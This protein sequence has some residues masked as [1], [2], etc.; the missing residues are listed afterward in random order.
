MFFTNQFSRRRISLLLTT[1]AFGLTVASAAEALVITN[2]FHFLD[3]TG[4]NP[5]GLAVGEVQQLGAFVSPSGPPTI[6]TA[7]QG[8]TVLN[9]VHTPHPIFP[10]DYELVFPFNPSLSGSWL[11]S[12]NRGSDSA[13]ATAQA[14]TPP[15]LLPLVDNLRVLG[16]GLTPT[17]LWEWPDLTGLNVDGTGIRVINALTTAQIYSSCSGQECIS[18]PPGDAGTPGEFQIPP[19]VLEF[20]NSYIFR[21]GLFDLREDGSTMN[22]SAT[23]TQSPFHPVPEP[24]TLFMFGIGALSLAGLRWKSRTGGNRTVTLA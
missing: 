9:L 14:I 12:A 4:P 18:F 19:G 5:V 22:R 11:I 10:N 13:T 1:I 2:P 3:H 6:V 7:T 16:S 21:V 8:T 15:I 23:F 17:L 20:C 24:S